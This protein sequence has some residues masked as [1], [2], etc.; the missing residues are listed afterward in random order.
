MGTLRFQC[1]PYYVNSAFYPTIDNFERVLKFAR[2]E[3]ADSKLDKLEALMVTQYGRP[4]EDVRFIA[5]IL[6]IPCEA[7]YG[8]LPITPQKFKDET[9][10]SLVDLTEAAARKQP[11]VML[12][13]DAHWADP[14]SLEVMDLL[15]DRIR[16]T[17]LLIVLT[18]RPEFQPKW[19]SH[20]HV[21]GLNLSKLTRAQS[22][23]IVSKL[24]GGKALPADLLE[25]ILAKTDGVPLY[26]EELT[27][28]ILESGEIKD[29]GDHYDYVGA[30][31]SVTIPATLRDSLMARLD[32]SSQAKEIAQIGAAIGREFSYELIAA[33]APDTK[34]ELDSALNQLTES[35]LAFR[36]GTPPDAHYTFKHA[37][38]QDAAYDSLLKSKRRELH[39]EIAEVVRG[40]F[41]AQAEAAPELLAHHYAEGA[42]FESAVHYWRVAAERAAAR[43]ATPEAIAHA[44]KGLAIVTQVAEAAVRT[45]QELA[46][47]VSLISSLRMADRLDE[48]LAQS[49]QAVSFAAQTERTVDLAR[50][51]HLRGNIYFPLGQFEQCLAEHQTSLE[52]ARKAKSTEDEI[53]AEGGLC[54]AYYMRGRMRS[55]HQHVERC[56][57]LCRTHGFDAIETAYLPMRALTHMYGLRFA[58]AL[59]D[60]RAVVE[61][62]A[63][64]GPPRAEI[65]SLSV[66]TQIFLEHHDF[67]QVDEHARRA[68]ELVERIGARRFVALFQGAIA[69]IRMHA[70]D[71]AGA[72]DLLEANMAISRETGI[73]FF[74]PAMLGA[75]ALASD[76]PKRREEA[77]REAQTIL[78]RGCVSQNYFRFYRDAIEVSLAMNEWD[79]ADLYATALEK[80]FHDEPMSW[81]SFIIA[82]GRALAELGRGRGGEATLSQIRQLHSEATRLNMRSELTRLEAALRLTPT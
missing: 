35:G 43:F 38:V 18:H 78:D 17:P 50:I 77:L 5:S 48:A 72:L 29:A 56:V 65:I 31:R 75:I 74:G 3:A 15:I 69:R 25:R 33:V 73:T 24:A 37:L 80:Y 45:Q 63:K 21:T 10:R 8:A 30:S 32:R 28:A 57:N 67:T 60:C 13:E 4:I 59:E 79:Q 82:R 12:Y 53:R 71:R 61:M 7:R 41:S 54:D 55:S 58:E 76:D 16:N 81:P 68:L 40:R 23:A 2:D 11:T 26:V 47:R 44:E 42:R 39:V 1:S 9:L 14:T 62:V 52:F 66:T 6:S 19:G 64:G 51:H 70:G 49:D 27:K 20:G 36:R 34:T 22:S 46:L